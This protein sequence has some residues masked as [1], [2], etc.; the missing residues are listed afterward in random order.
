MHVVSTE[1]E[2]KPTYNRRSREDWVK[3]IQSWQDST[4][5]QREYCAQHG[6]ALSSFYAWRQKLQANTDDSNSSRSEDFVNVFSGSA[7]D[8]PVDAGTWRIELDLGDITLRLS[9]R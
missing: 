2:S 1:Q 8:F 9:R 4:L 6:I 7:D 3:I 5:S